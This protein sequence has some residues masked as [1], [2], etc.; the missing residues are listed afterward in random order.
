MVF[1][2]G[3]ERG[4]NTHDAMAKRIAMQGKEWTEK[5]WRL[6]D[7]QACASNADVAWLT[8]QMPFACTSSG[9]V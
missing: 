2:A 6:V 7:M 3:D 4:R 8:R 5:H 9:L 1:F